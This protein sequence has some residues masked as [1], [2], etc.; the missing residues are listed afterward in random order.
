MTLPIWKPSLKAFFDDRASEV[1]AVPTLRELCFIAGRDPRLWSDGELYQDMIDSISGLCVI[2]RSSSILELGC[3]AGF[4]AKGIAPRVRKYHGVDIAPQTIKVAR[5]LGLS[6]ATFSVAD[7]S[8]LEFRSDSFD[9]AFCYDVF[10]NFP[11]FA[12]GAPLIR[13]MFRVVRPGGK[14]V[15][16]SIPDAAVRE[17]FQARV[18]VVQGKL[19]ERYGPV[20]P[21][22]RRAPVGHVMQL[23]E[24]LTQR[25]AAENVEPKIVCYYFDRRDFV[26]LGADLSAAVT[27]TD[28]HG[29]NPYSGF[30]FNVVYEKLLRP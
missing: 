1:A 11:D 22:P 18:K 4:I 7:G 17:D 6:N 21:E 10:T 5:R 15:V 3:A 28:V 25:R 16:G 24:R 20:G 12:D 2:D 14:I 13:E 26:A 8:S 9:A 27:I 19:N 23:W 29:K 30:R